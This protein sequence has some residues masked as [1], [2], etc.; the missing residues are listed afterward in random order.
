MPNAD[1]LN[2]LEKQIEKGPRNRVV[3]T[4]ETRKSDTAI[5]KVRKKS[6]ILR[7]RRARKGISN[8]FLKK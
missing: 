1:F 5:P 3:K 4:R 7:A 8:N 6:L 2:L